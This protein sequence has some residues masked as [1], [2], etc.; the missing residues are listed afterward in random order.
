ML[1]TD[2]IIIF[3]NPYAENIF[4]QLTDEHDMELMESEA[5]ILA[6][7][8]AGADWQIAAVPVGNWNHDLT[9]WPAKPVFSRQGF[10]DGAPQTLRA[11]WET[12]IPALAGAREKPR[13]F[14]L[15]G[16][17][18]AGLF[19]LWAAYQTDAF[20]GVVAASPS[21]WYPEW[22][23]YAQRHLIRASAVY[24]SLGDK[25]EKAR[26]PVMATVGDAI[27]RQ[28]RLLLEAGTLTQL[29]WNPGNHFQD[30]DKRIAKGMAW[31]LEQTKGQEER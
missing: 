18:L 15:C 30:S 29:D 9:P 28:H 3:G 7:L 11:I 14:Y 12:V 21:V 17:S 13:R 31:I 27:R 19:A 22:I 6:S 26:N 2:E 10:G 5:A 25:E 1:N 23:A 20:S 16:Y 24:L 8:Y 4:I